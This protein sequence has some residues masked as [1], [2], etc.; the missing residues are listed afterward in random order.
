MK[1][2]SII[3]ASAH[4]DDTQIK[5]T[6]RFFAWTLGLPFLGFVAR[7]TLGAKTVLLTNMPTSYQWVAYSIGLLVGIAAARVVWREGVKTASRF[8][9]AYA[10]ITLIVLS[11]VT[12]SYLGR[13][14]Y[15]IAAFVNLDSQARAGQV[16]IMQ[17][18]S[19]KS[20]AFAEVKI[21]SL[22][23]A[24]D[25]QI[26]NDLYAD[27]AAIRP[28][29]WSKTYDEESVCLTLP[30]QNGRWGAI[31]AFIPARWENGLNQDSECRAH[32]ARQ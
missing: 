31:R 17:V 21:S 24:A 22:D 30:L 7:E 18:R 13:W 20:G 2:V 27:L 26:A 9:T 11:V 5:S 25:V 19:A 6:R 14:A 8:R 1:G 16:K 4:V 32:I 3:A 28:P 10:A 29:L 23:R 15:E 12:A